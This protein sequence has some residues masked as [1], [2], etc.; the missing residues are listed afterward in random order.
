MNSKRIIK[1]ASLQ[2]E[3]LNQLYINH[4]GIDKTKVLAHKPIYWINMNA[5]I[6]EMVK[7]CPTCL[8]FPATQPKDKIIPYKKPGMLWESVR[9]K[10]FAINNKYMYYLCIVEYKS[11]FP[12]FSANNLIQICEIIFTE[13][14]LAS[15]IVSDA[16]TNFV[17]KKFKNFCKPLSIHHAASSSYNHQSNRPAKEGIMFLNEP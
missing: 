3:V 6:E 5:H 13:Y 9:A 15:K 1:Q 14:R 12:L 17:S 7:N 4:V 2:G 8:D 10:F 11:K 16:G